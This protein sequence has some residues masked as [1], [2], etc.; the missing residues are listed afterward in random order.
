MV[1]PTEIRFIGTCSGVEI[2]TDDITLNG[3][4]GPGPHLGGVG[5]I[6]GTVSIVGARRIVLQNLTIEGS[7]NGI[8]GSENATFTLDHV[9]V[10]GNDEVGVFLISGAVATIK[11]SEITDNGKTADDFSGIN[12]ST[13]G[14]VFLENTMVVDN[15]LGDPCQLEVQM[16][17]AVIVA[18]NTLSTSIGATICVFDLGSVRSFSGGVDDIIEH[19][20]GGLALRLGRQSFAFLREAAITGN[21]IINENSMLET[22]GVSIAGDVRLNQAGYGHFRK[23]STITGNLDVL[24]NGFAQLNDLSITGVLNVETGA[25]VNAVS[26]TTVGGGVFCRL[27]GLVFSDIPALRC[28]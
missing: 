1:G 26:G 18:G 15:G 4:P 6:S 25:V 23:N 9:V 5:T 11:D 12:V 21:V 28:P 2:R 16:G 14:L 27:S 10:D 17:R 19:T 7:G 3:V 20:S 22:R 13:N 24:Q 8:V